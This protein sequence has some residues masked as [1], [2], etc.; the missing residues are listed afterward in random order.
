MFY[1]KISVF[2]ASKRKGYILVYSSL[3]SIVQLMFY[4][5]KCI[6]KGSERL[7]FNLFFFNKTTNVLLQK[8]SVQ[9]QWE[10]TCGFKSFLISIVCLMLYYE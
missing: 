1:Y 7:A 2:K 9:N 10:A 6:F 8:I 3:I 4:Y 5:K